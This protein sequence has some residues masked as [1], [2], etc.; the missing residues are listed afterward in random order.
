MPP[1]TIV[2]IDQNCH[3]L[4]DVVPKLHALARAGRPAR[5]LVEDIDV[6]FTA[7]GGSPDDPLRMVR[8]RFHHSGGQDW[9]AALFYSE[10]MGRLPLDLRDLEPYLGQK[11]SAVAR[12]CGTSVEELYNAHSPSDNWQLI[13]PSYVTET[14]HRVI[15]DLRVGETAPFL[16]EMLDIARADM[17]RSFPAPDAR[18]RTASWFQQQRAMLDDLLT[19]H[20]D[21][22]LAD[23]YDDWLTRSTGDAATVGRTSDRF[24]LHRQAEDPLVTLFLGDYERAAELYNQAL[25]DA[26]SSLHPLNVSKGELPLFAT[27]ERE[28]RRVRTEMALDGDTLHLAGE[29]LALGG[30]GSL[31]VDALAAAGVRAIAGKAVLLVLQVRTGPAAASLAL[32]RQGSLYTPASHALQRRLEEAGCLAGPVKPILRVRLALLD[33]LAEVDTPIR[34]PEYLAAVAGTDELPATKLAA[35]WR[36]W[37]EDA[38]RRLKAM[39]SDEGR[40]AWQRDAMPELHQQID[41]MDTRR[42]ELARENPKGEE[43]RELS[44]RIREL[45]ST[46]AGRTLQQVVRDT[47]V[48][49]LDYWDSRGATW[50]WCIALGGETFYD[51]LLEQAEI[52]PETPENVLTS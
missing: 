26:H 40:Q 37:R 39:Q 38:T 32:P 44:H 31:P 19:R 16:R 46:V 1:E 36:S 34:L 10:F 13:G 43:I 21:A 2:S 9:G 5:H 15:G 8:E 18:K 35:Q 14:T 27:L 20:E 22:G 50:P 41:E 28:G 51:R 52:T 23:L 45:Q 48:S 11:L 17:D 33:R 49:Q 24:A 3:P 6:A 29:T 30:D 47:H 4:W 12:R 7:L 25:G 42:R